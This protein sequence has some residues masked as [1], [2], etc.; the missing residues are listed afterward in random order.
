MNGLLPILLV[1]LVLF[2][3][4]LAA[5]SSFDVQVCNAYQ[6]AA[7]RQACLADLDTM[8]S[9]PESGPGR[10]PVS[11]RELTLVTMP[12]KYLGWNADEAARMTG[13]LMNDAGQ[14]V[15]EGSAHEL[16]L[17]IGEI[18]EVAAVG[19]N[20]LHH[21]TCD[22]RLAADDMALISSLGLE[23]ATLKGITP[24]GGLRR[25]YSDRETRLKIRSFC[26]GRRGIP[27]IQVFMIYQRPPWPETSV[28]AK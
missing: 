3:G 20:F 1:A 16:V 9:P 28:P 8:T 2:A 5:N 17:Y 11:E 26:V 25:T 22:P 4:E 13:A 15:W 23:S 24:S 6:K 27:G 7:V 19:I 10:E 14:L 21:A 18:E 12:N